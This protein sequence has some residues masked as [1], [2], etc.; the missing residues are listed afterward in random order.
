MKKVQLGLAMLLSVFIISCSD[1]DDNGK[2]DT[3]APDMIV[4]QDGAS[5]EDTG[6]AADTGPAEDTGPAADT[7]P[8]EGACTN[9]EDGPL[10]DTAEK[11][12]AVA[13]SAQTCG[14]GCLQDAD[15]G[16]CSATCVAD[17]TG[18]STECSACYAG[19]VL[20]SIQ[21]CLA[22]CSA[23][24]TSQECAQCQAD[25]CLEDFYTCSGLTPES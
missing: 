1:D 9:A 7:G 10:L 15:P 16:A 6:P 4:Q 5:A 14:L 22:A 11:R 13:A 20:C 2:T 24:P 12:D 8:A 19:I 21:N 3:G 17:D 23:D 25:N 18:L